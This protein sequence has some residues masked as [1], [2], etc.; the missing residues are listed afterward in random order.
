VT[1]KGIEVA[2]TTTFIRQPTL[3][4][5]VTW[6]FAALS[7][8]I[9]TLRDTTPI[10]F[11]ASSTQQ[12]R[13]GYPAGSY[14]QTPYTYADADNDGVI[15]ADEVTPGEG[16]Q[17]IGNPLPRRTLAVQPV[18]TLG[19]NGLLRL[20]ATVDYR[21]GWYQYNNTQSFRCGFAICP[22]LYLPGSALDEQARGIA[23]TNYGTDFGY[24]EKADFV[25]L[26]EVSATVALPRVLRLGHARNGALTLAG[27]N[28]FT[29]SKYSGLDP[30]ANGGAQANW[31]QFDF[32]SQPPVR[33]FSARLSFNY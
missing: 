12:H 24:I 26:R 18:L 13:I 8:H 3:G 16:S 23:A 32:L 9:Y 31:S 19:P 20:Q 30:E 29:S 22:E 7:N 17:F 11:G 28:L 5:D 15:T 25:K 1:N 27:R 4:L 6:N 33:L 10:I 2:L 14:F 21:G